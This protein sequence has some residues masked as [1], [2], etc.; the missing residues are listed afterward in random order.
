MIDI[1]NNP[2]NPNKGVII[3]KPN[4]PNVYT[5]VRKDYTGRDVT[6]INF[7][8]VIKG[9]KAAMSGIGSGRVLESGPNDNVFINFVRLVIY[10]LTAYI[11]IFLLFSIYF[12]IP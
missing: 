1:A 5:G 3:N 8:N 12:L 11:V 6:P 7:L 4:G 10:M 9:N 2:E